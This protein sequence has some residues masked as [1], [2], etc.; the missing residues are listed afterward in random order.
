MDKRE[1]KK[2]LKFVCFFLLIIFFL[3]LVYHYSDIIFGNKDLLGGKS[4]TNIKNIDSKLA[5]EK[6]NSILKKF[7]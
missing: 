6:I 1:N 7:I 4:V 5:Y 3:V 2:K